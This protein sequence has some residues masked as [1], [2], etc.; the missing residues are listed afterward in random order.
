MVGDSLAVPARVR[1]ERDRS[2]T[3]L[4]TGPR[5]EVEVGHTRL[6]GE[7]WPLARAG[8]ARLFGVPDSELLSVELEMPRPPYGQDGQLVRI[9]Q[10]DGPESGAIGQAQWFG[11]EG[12]WW[13]TCAETGTGIYPGE[14]LD[15]DPVVAVQE[16][17][18]LNVRLAQHR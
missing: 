6:T 8:A 3:V 12:A 7:T 9:T 10:A 2:Y 13:V 11:A 16:R 5:G 14:V 4:V 15:F 17:A 1:H 18:D